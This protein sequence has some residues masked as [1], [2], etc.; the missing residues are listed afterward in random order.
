MVADPLYVHTTTEILGQTL[1]G[2]K[3]ESSKARL[4]ARSAGFGVL[5]RVVS[6][7][8][9]CSTRYFPWYHSSVQ[10]K[11]MTPQQPCSNIAR[12]CHSRVSACFS[13]PLRRLSRPISL[14]STGL[15]LLKLCNLA[16]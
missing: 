3:G 13:S 12:T 1:L 4:M 5:S 8:F 15:S 10:A 9:H 7:N 14:I 6:P 2:G 16:R 11:T